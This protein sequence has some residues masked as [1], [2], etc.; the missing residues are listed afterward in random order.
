MDGNKNKLIF[1]QEVSIMNTNWHQYRH[2]NSK[3]PDT[4]FLDRVGSII[5]AILVAILLYYLLPGMAAIK[6]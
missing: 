2:L 4:P 1:D 5:L 3:R 6:G